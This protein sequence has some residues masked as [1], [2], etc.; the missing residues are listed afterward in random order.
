MTKQRTETSKM[1]FEQ[2]EQFKRLLALDPT[3]EVKKTTLESLTRKAE[4][5]LTA[6]LR[7]KGMKFESKHE[8]SDWWEMIKLQ[9]PV[10]ETDYGWK[11][12]SKARDWADMEIKTWEFT[13]RYVAI[14]KVE[15]LVNWLA[16]GRKRGY[17]NMEADID[18]LLAKHPEIA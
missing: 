7:I 2:V 16:D 15:Q 9:Y 13:D 5:L 3:N 18:R 1:V 14:A 11:V 8:G 17:G 12:T 6:E 10:T 4:A